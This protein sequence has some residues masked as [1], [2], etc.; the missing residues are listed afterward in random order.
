MALRVGGNLVLDQHMTN[1]GGLLGAL[2][3]HE[4]VL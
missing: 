3:G 4:K 1:L 2:H